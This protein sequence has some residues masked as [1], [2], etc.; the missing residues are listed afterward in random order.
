[1]PSLSKNQFIVLAIIVIAITLVIIVN[2]LK[3]DGKNNVEIGNN[4]IQNTDT[5]NKNET[6]DKNDVENEIV[7][8]GNIEQDESNNKENQINTQPQNAQ[9][10]Q[11]QKRVE[12]VT[13]KNSQL[14]FKD[15]ISPTPVQIE[16]FLGINLSNMES[17]LV[18]ISK[19]KFSSELYMIFKPTEEYKQEAKEQIKKFLL[20]YES[21]WSKINEEQ[22]KLVEDRTAIERSG[23]II[24][25]I[26]IENDTI[27]HEIR[28]II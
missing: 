5:V 11:I 14:I 20:N 27:M 16:E 23:Y 7:V 15:M 10:L 28:K 24:Y 25:I 22:Y 21:A 9:L 17:Y 19:D 12:V 4:D 18:R 13:D 26:S 1:M 3:D 8:D 2:I 6:D